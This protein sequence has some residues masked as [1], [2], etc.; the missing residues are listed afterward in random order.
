MKTKILLVL[1][2][3][4]VLISFVGSS[5]IFA[6]TDKEINVDEVEIFIDDDSSASL[7][8]RNKILDQVKEHLIISCGDDYSFEN[9]SIELTN[10]K[11]INRK[12]VVDANIFVDMTLIRNPE[13]M[14]FIVGM[15]EEAQYLKTRE[16][17]DIADK[18]ISLF[19][20]DMYERY[21]TP[22]PIS[23]YYAIEIE[24][25]HLKMSQDDNLEFALFTRFDIDSDNSILTP[26]DA[27]IKDSV[28]QGRNNVNNGKDALSEFINKELQNNSATVKNSRASVTYYRLDARDYARDHREDS[29][30]FYKDGNSDC[31]NFVS[32]CVNYG[33][34][35]EDKTNKWYGASTWGDL[36]TAGT[37]WYRTGYYK[38]SGS[39]KYEGVTTYL[40]DRDY[41]YST[42]KTS[43]VFAGS[44][45][46]VTDASH[47]G[48]ITYGDGSK[49]YYADHSSTKKS[50]RETLLTSS[51]Y[52]NR[53]KFFMP[54]SSI[55]GG[56]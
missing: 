48:L 10:P 34:I 27:A 56:E 44:I 17:K 35:P 46:F 47:V 19:L 23:V 7:S 55:L 15:R 16:E 36:N 52:L 2:A 12:I 38:Q 40:T 32:K 41:F 8:L 37:W 11:I 50:G 53:S 13:E 28:L 9:Y 22:S 21:N 45:L 43:S 24:R 5:N 39:G 3:I 20:T 33:G 26:I 25:S 29:P 14:P 49:L 4:T 54:Y 30:E 31:A 51:N 1:L 6:F 42:T 18:Y